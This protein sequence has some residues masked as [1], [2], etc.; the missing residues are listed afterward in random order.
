[1]SGEHVCPPEHAHAEM[2]TCYSAHRCRCTDCRQAH[3]EYEFYRR[4]MI[5]AGRWQGRHYVDARGARRRVQALMTLGWSQSE[6][7][8]RLGMSQNQL[9]EIAERLEVITEGVA[10]RVAELY[11]E[12][13]NVRPVPTTR[14]ERV[15]VSHALGRAKRLGYAPPMAWDDIDLDEGPQTGIEVDV[16]DARVALAVDGVRVELTTRE[17]E[18]VVREL[19]ARGLLDTAIAQQIGVAANTVLRIRQRLGLPERFNQINGLP[20]YRG[21]DAA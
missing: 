1:M 7:A 14:G 2:T 3:T 16:D 9:W 20:G 12:L 15:S 6:I 17:R 13:W 10:E 8:R 11:E 19:N 5:R 18:E 4:G 21:E